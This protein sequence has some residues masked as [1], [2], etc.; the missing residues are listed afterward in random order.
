MYGTW[1]RLLRRAMGVLA[2]LASVLGVIE[3]G[4]RGAFPATAVS[5]LD[6]VTGISR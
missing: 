5:S 6:G 2:V 3:N 4:R 1:P